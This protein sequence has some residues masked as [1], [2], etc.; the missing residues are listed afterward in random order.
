MDADLQN[1]SHLVGLLGWQSLAVSLLVLGMVWGLTLVVRRVA[2]TLSGPF[3]AWRLAILQ[4]ETLLSFALWLGGA[5]LVVV[6]VLRPASGPMLALAGSLAVAIGFALKDVVASVVAGLIL[7]FDVPFQV[8]D[9][10]TF[11]GHFGDIVRIGLRTVRIRTLSDDTV[12]V[13]N[14]RFLTDAV[15]SGNAGK[16][17]MMVTC[18]FH[19]ALDTDVARAAHLL[20]EVV[21]TSRYAYLARPVEVVV[22]EVAVAGRL[23]LRFTTKAYVLDVRHQEAF[24][25]DQFRRGTEVLRRAGFARPALLE[26]AAAHD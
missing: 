9:R 1:V 23:A 8:G 7:L 24:Q 5:A 13:P 26:P 18:D 17:E 12:T 2:E 20:R 14:L 19:L 6:G 11:D 10:V 4:V 15:A 25:T 3:P 16:L 22:K 21:L